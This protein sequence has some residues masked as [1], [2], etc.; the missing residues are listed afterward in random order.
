M[1]GSNYFNYRTSISL[2]HHIN[3]FCEWFEP[4]SH[5][6]NKWNMI[7]PTSV[8]Q[9]RTAVFDVRTVYGVVMFLI[10]VSCISSTLV[11]D[12]I[13]QLTRDMLL[14]VCQ[15]SHDFVGYEDS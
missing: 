13:G 1:R 11:I 15:L 7:V 4:R 14:V 12:L 6:I 8:V 9:N 5:V 3:P 2:L 10:K